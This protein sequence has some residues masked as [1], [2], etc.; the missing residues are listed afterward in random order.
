MKW[1]VQEFLME[2]SKHRYNNFDFVGFYWVEEDMEQTDGLAK[3]ISA[4]LHNLGY[5]HYWKPYSTAKGSTYWDEYDFDYCYLQPGGYCINKDRNISRVVDALEKA[6]RRGAGMLYEFDS[7]IFF[8]PELY[9]PRLHECIDMFEKY[10]VYK[11]SSMTYY[12]GALIIYSIYKGKYGNI[13]NTPKQIASIREVMDRIAEHIVKRYTDRYGLP[14][15]NP[16]YQS[17]SNQSPAN[18]D[19]NDWRNPE[20]WHF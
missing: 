5:K 1:Y 19:N 18:T 14:T 3:Q 4:Y 10:G 15:N 16:Y 20:Y 11:N 6:K 12:E 17:P 8:N 9:V 13:K 7:R 2:F